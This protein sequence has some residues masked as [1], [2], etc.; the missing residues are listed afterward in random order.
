MKKLILIF[1]V[2]FLI[3]SCSS[4]KNEYLIKIYE[5]KLDEAGVPSGYVN[6]KGD[7]IVP[8]GKFYYCYTDTIRNFG[9][10]ME[11]EN[12][13]IFAIDKNAAELFEVF[14]FDN[15][16][17]YIQD[18]LFRIIKNGK[19]GYANEN[20]EIVIEPKFDCAYPFKNGIAKVSNKCTT[21]KSGEHSVWESNDW[22]YIN[23]KGEQV[24]K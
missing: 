18:G 1:F 8:V 9:F 12:G 13:R 17:D 24:E 20:G 5:G 19:I 6:E 21:K 4:N 14:K 23:K 16:P 3:I 2:T 10:V 11:N 22:F 7:T 15:G